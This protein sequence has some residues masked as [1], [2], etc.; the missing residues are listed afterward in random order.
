MIFSE[1]YGAYYNTMAR[2][3]ERAIEHPLEKGELRSIVNE[4][5]FDESILNIDSAIA[6]EKWQLI[7]KDGTTPIQ[8]VPS[9]PL[10]LL[11]K[12]WLKAISSDPRMKL[13][14]DA[15]YIRNFR[16]ILD[17]IRNQYPLK[18]TA[19]SHKGRELY[20]VLMPERLEY[21]EKDDK[22]RL[23][24]TGRKYEDTVNLGRIKS[25]EP[26]KQEYIPRGNT[27]SNRKTRVSQM[28][29]RETFCRC[30][31]RIRV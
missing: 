2:I 19:S 12:R 27:R 29:R 22:F 10:T 25:C 24:G 11:Q 30:L 26:Y 17:A 5:A 20:L 13:F 21:S 16:L 1:I 7:K 18:I 31:N 28:W 3:I 14:E 6:E 23:I 15:A 4:Y 8:N 9:M